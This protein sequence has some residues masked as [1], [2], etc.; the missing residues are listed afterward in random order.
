[1]LKS[2]FK[3][4][5]PPVGNQPRFTERTIIR[6]NPNQKFGIASPKNDVTVI[7]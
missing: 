1:M 6:I 7:P 4:L 2:A 3:V 5:T